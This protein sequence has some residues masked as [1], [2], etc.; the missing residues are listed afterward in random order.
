[1][2]LDGMLSLKS[3]QCIVFNHCDVIQTFKY[4]LFLPSQLK[5]FTSSWPVSNCGGIFLLTQAEAHRADVYQVIRIWSGFLIRLEVSWVLNHKDP[6]S[7]QHE[8]I[9]IGLRA[10]WPPLH[11]SICV[12]IMMCNCCL[13]MLST[14]GKKKSETELIA[15]VLT[16]KRYSSWM[17]NCS[18]SAHWW[19][20]LSL[21]LYC[22][23]VVPLPQL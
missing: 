19:D 12:W 1:M 3:R 20:V 15:S 13:L 7:V 22:K 4:V 16:E 8:L 10:T 2:P 17:R 9:S 23:T 5:K 6:R 14:A 11:L 21:S 18:T